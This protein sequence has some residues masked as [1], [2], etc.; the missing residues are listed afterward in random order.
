MNTFDDSEHFRVQAIYCGSLLGERAYLQRK[1]FVGGRIYDGSSVATKLFPAWKLSVHDIVG[2]YALESLELCFHSLWQNGFRMLASISYSELDPFAFP[3]VCR[4]SWAS[5]I[6]LLVWG[7]WF[8]AFSFVCLVVTIIFII[9]MVSGLYVKK[10]GWRRS[11]RFWGSTIYI[12]SCLRD[13]VN[14]EFKKS[15]EYPH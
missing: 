2:I 7:M 8:G 10:L 3:E 13:W 4:F 11:R 9:K 15:L 14:G 6:H 12:T 1:V 5:F